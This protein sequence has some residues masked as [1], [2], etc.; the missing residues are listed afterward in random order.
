MIIGGVHTNQGEVITRDFDKADHV[1]R[2][3]EKGNWYVIQTNNDIYRDADE[4]YHL[5]VAAMEKIGKEGVTVD[6]K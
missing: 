2:L 4:R 1:S 3:G 5:A 6:G